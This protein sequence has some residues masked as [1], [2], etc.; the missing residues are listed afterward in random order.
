VCVVLAGCGLDHSSSTG[1]GDDPPAQ[2]AAELTEQARLQQVSDIAQRNEKEVDRL[3]KE[4]QAAGIENEVRAAV[5]RLILAS[6]AR[7]V[8][9]GDL[10]AATW[11]EQQVSGKTPA[12]FIA[13]FPEK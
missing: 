5:S 4:G 6:N 1:I 11:F 10:S 9:Q 13:A 7:L 8:E 3:I 2:T 12:E